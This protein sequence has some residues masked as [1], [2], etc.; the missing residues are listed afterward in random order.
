MLV[1]LIQR[2]VQIGNKVTFSLKSGQ[3]VSGI[4][5]EIGRDHI[6]LENKKGTATI[7][8]EMIGAWEV[9][10][11]EG[12]GTEVGVSE[13]KPAEEDQVTDTPVQK[14]KKTDEIKSAQPISTKDLAPTVKRLIEIE[15]RFQ[16][17]LRTAE[18]EL[19]E[20][21]F[22]FPSNEI[23]GRHR[24]EA[25]KVWNRASNRY[26][27]AKKINE[28]SK[29][30]GRIQLITHDLTS[31]AEHFPKSSAVKRH[32]AYC[33]L[34]L[35]KRKEALDCYRDAATI[36]QGA[37]DWHN[38]AVSALET[39][40]ESLACYALEQVFSKVPVTE[41]PDAWYAYVGLLKKTG[42]YPALARLCETREHD[43]SE[44]EAVF[45]LETGIYLLK[46]KGKE[47]VAT[48]LTHQWLEEQ[49]AL[50]RLISETF[51]QLDDKPSE[52]Y[53]QVVAKFSKDEEKTKK[54]K[55]KVLQQPKGYIYAYRK[56][57]YFGFLRDQSGKEYFFH[58][59]AV[60]DATLYDRLDNLGRGERIPVVFK[61]TEGPKGPLALRVALFRTIDELFKVAT[62]CARNGEYARAIGYIKQVLDRDLEYPEAQ[63][64]YEKWREY[65]RVTGVPKG[66]NPYARAKRVQ[67]IEKDLGRA[68]RLLRQAI[69]EEDNLESAIKDLA[70]L[71][72]QQGHPEQAIKFLQKN[73]KKIQDQRSVDNLLQSFYWSAGQYDQAVALLRKKLGRTTAK[74]KRVQVLWQIA[75]CYLR[76][77]DYTQA[78]Q[79]FK[80]VL[81][82]HP[83]NRGAR[84]NIAICHFKQQQFDEAERILNSIL[85]TAPDVRAAE[86]LEAIAQARATGESTQVDEIIIETTLSD[87]SGETSGFTQFFLERCE[88]QGVPPSR[89]QT[90]E[91]NSS[92]IKKLE[93]LATRLGTRRP[94]D[95]AGYYLS[96]SR[97]TSILEGESSNQFY[98][99]LCRS[100][101]SSGDA[102]IAESKPLDA[103]RELYCEALSIYDRDRSKSK[104]EQDAVNALVRFLFSTLGRAQVPL[105]PKIPSIDETIEQVLRRHP[106]R[107][108]VFDA[109]AY[110]VFRSRYAAN[111]ILKR[112]YAGSSL[113]AM[114]LDYL[115]SQ[116]T[117][118]A[119][120]VKQ[121]NDFVRLWNGL[122][123]HRFD[124][125]RAISNEFRFLSRVELTTAS[126]EAGI[127]RL[128]AVNHQ[129]FF[130]LDQERSRRLQTVL[131]TIL[132][133]VKQDS[134]EEQ[135]R[136][137][138]QVNSRCDD[139]LREIERSP[140]KLSVEELYS[141]V[142]V[143]QNKVK[144]YLED[145]YASSIPQLELRS[146]KESYVPD[147]NRQIEIQIVV[148]NKMG[149]SPAEALELIVQE[150]ADLFTVESAEI[151]LDESLRGGTQR[152]L[153][154]PLR[155]THQASKSQTFSL[156]MYAQYRT[157]SG[158]TEETEV[159]SFSI[160]L[161][162]E[163]EFETIENPYARY[164]E[165]GIVD[166]PTM[167]YGRDELIDD[168]TRVI[169]ES[170]SQSK[171]VVVFGQK[172]SGK[173]SILYHLK[174][175]LERGGDLLVLDLGNIGSI[176]DEQSSAPFLYQ[177]LWSILRKLEYA[178]ED[179]IVDEG[180]SPLDLVFPSDSEF[181]NH[182]SPLILFKDVF[183]RYRRKASKTESWRNL[184]VVLLIDE[185]SYIYG[186]IV[187]GL[188]PE[189][190][191]KNWK[192]LLQE[193]YFSVVLAGQD[194]M[195]KFKQHFPN[196]FGTTQ[197]E[198]V[199][200]LKYSDAVKLIDE[201]IRI[202]G[203]QGESRYRERAI[204]LIVDLTAGSPFYIQI[205]C[206]RLV[207]Y[208]N[209]KRA[210]LVT[211]ADVEH[212]KN[213]LVRGVNAL[214]LDKFDNLI[215]SGDTSE[216]AISDEDA[217][218]VLKAI[219][220]NSRT[221]PCNH[222]SIA[223]ETQTPVDT[224][225]NDLVNREVI[226]R[227][228]ER[229]YQIRVGLFNDWLIAH[230]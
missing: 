108:Q 222:N 67:L 101:A 85:D 60:I 180:F 116:G 170:R 80:E 17:Q 159:H 129:L 165:A 49:E 62:D 106:Q 27:Y 168:I 105:T 151:K 186:L 227:E 9:L 25:A 206:D 210:R 198:R 76:Q 11:G 65:V 148:A 189:L 169:Q 88:F 141:V 121:F 53:Q 107:D 114:A 143:V 166:D 56:A 83:D 200:Y 115:D 155:I 182:Q 78:K 173:S 21:D 51:N 103:A 112:L 128:K 93:E 54:P 5:V 55:G 33:Y 64:L 150:D 4:L 75:N 134:F 57:R 81:K 196:E 226:E 37:S 167:F 216:D 123:R 91:F 185:F 219:A 34:L 142:Q 126:L 139:L 208:M 77:E 102:T 229:Y 38:V 44:E 66:S 209:R 132:D 144:E 3:E 7:L 46:N 122:R 70:N 190:F 171:S 152:V 131:E 178:I 194:V 203:R 214:G 96:A 90:K 23:S 19:E 158:E 71:L 218:K 30:F 73:R 213:E 135:E 61:A 118:V 202:G 184:Q 205:I 59:S 215:N 29:K 31:L 212:V 95:R 177:I 117:Q 43:L 136:L 63:D 204:D 52:A 195:P 58:R 130:D 183:D 172:R 24:K 137:C 146:P 100:F 15:A 68:A 98:R 84:R 35:G 8:V 2:Q 179:M 22:S 20:P 161:Y 225:L 163:E 127:E 10:E 94:R 228:R 50:L 113:Q 176:L 86:L 36:S 133:L 1:Q 120:P 221:G 192:A 156:P 191:M 124:E 217:L 28:L 89:A 16:S 197:D 6:T 14:T 199:S 32:L 162:P 12:P 174:R 42:N 41:N 160:R 18:I 211:E 79:T 193:N 119:H 47:D 99:Y 220:L 26:E 45:L 181:Y 164:A 154:F 224:I 111:R 69:K 40:E 125:W 149:R 140:T 97:I 230:Q 187:S 175:K 223:C 188:I 72:V 74:E 92:D 13:A 82:L 48:N 157:R 138:I 39:D 109:I 104:G 153:E 147:N 87:F 201:P 207:K 145:L 110:L